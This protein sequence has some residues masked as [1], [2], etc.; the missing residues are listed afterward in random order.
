MLYRNATSRRGVGGYGASRFAWKAPP[1]C[2]LLL[3]L[4]GKMHASLRNVMLN[5]RPVGVSA[6]GC[7]GTMHWAGVLRSILGEEALDRWQ[8]QAERA[9]APCN[10][11]G[12]GR[13]GCALKGKE[14]LAGILLLLVEFRCSKLQC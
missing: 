4:D 8:Q 11:A 10:K 2:A 5:Q 1:A 13:G 3:P 7:R 6:A 14:R 12:R 9:P